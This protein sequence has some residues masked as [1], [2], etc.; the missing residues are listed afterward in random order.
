MKALRGA[1]ASRLALETGDVSVWSAVRPRRLAPHGLLA[2]AG[3]RGITSLVFTRHEGPP[4]LRALAERTSG[5]RAVERASAP[6]R[7]SARRHLEMALD[8]IVA[9]FNGSLGPPGGPTR[10]RFSVPVDLSSRGTEFQR[11]VWAALLEIPFGAVRAY[12]DVA[13]AVGRPSAARAVGGAVG[14]NPVAIIVPC[15]RVVGRD[16]SLTGFSSGLPLK[17]ILLDVEGI[18]LPGLAAG[19]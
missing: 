7:S 1:R 15:H 8:E 13:A 10:G 9:Y 2:V 11:R 19:R 5:G 16:G 18:V 17:R 4:A 12:G 14:R 6:A 3:E